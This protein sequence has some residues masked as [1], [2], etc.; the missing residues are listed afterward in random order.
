ME[1]TMK[2]AKNKFTLLKQ[3]VENIPPYLV[4]KLARKHEV[5]KKSRTFSP[6]SHV[7]SMIFAHL[8]H[9]LSLNDIS[10][11]LRHHAGALATVRGAQPPSRNGLSHANKVRNA[12]MAK[13][14][15]YET[16]HQLTGHFPKFGRTDTSFKLPRRI[17]RVI[18]LVDST[19]I[20][21]F[22]NCMDWAKHRR[23]KAAAKCHLMLDALTFL[24]RFAVVGSAKSHDAVKGRIL[25]N[26][27]KDGEIVVFDK[28]YVDFKHL[29]ELMQR[30]ILWVTRAKTN[31]SYKI[32]RRLKKS[33]K[34]IIRDSEIRLKGYRS[35][36]D[37]P[38]TL[39]LIVANVVRDGKTV[40]ME[41]ITDNFE[42]SAVT[43]C[44]LYK[45]RWDIELFFKQLK[46]TLKLSD[47][48]GYSENAVQWQIWTALLTYVVLRFI[49]YMSKWK[50]TFAR[51]FTTVRGVLWSRFDM[52]N[53]LIADFRSVN[54]TL[55]IITQRRSKVF[56]FVT[57]VF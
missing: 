18:N 46:Q 37:Y 53:L 42:F 20:Q 5:D 32:V 9:A 16:L 11:T 13:D 24:P 43:I 23:R 52:Y 55:I 48:L 14:L 19:T 22:A 12:E 44:E 2:P 26:Q 29:F 30:G 36:K 21:L 57:T 28:A 6:W 31:M 17:K 54:Y 8:S 51:L 35:S 1:V 34:S 45:A 47:F 4:P 15:F 33:H 50:G 56:D 38:Q 3:V 49:A 7:V 40:R 10:D 39:R 25:C 27:L 41:F